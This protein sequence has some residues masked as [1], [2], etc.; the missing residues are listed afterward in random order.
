MVIPMRQSPAVTF[1]CFW[2]I[3]VPG[4]MTVTFRGQQ[5]SVR[6]CLVG[7][8]EFEDEL[9]ANERLRGSRWSRVMV[10]VRR[11][12]D[13]AH[14][15]CVFEYRGWLVGYSDRS[16]ARVL[17]RDL[18]LKDRPLEL[19]RLWTRGASVERSFYLR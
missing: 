5:G 8:I 17:S 1:L 9:M 16:G 4:C 15:V 11:D 19:A 6:D 7:A 3:L 14:A 2:S 10:M 12:R 18:S 13:L